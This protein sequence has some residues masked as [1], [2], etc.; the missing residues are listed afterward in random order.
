[1]SSTA[2]ILKQFANGQIPADIPEDCEYR[3]EL[4]QLREYLTSLSQFVK[5]LSAGDLSNTTLR[6]PGSL[7]GSLKGLHANLR[8]L[9]W[10]TQQVAA[11]DLNQRVDFLGDFSVAFNSMVS[12]LAQARDDLTQKNQQLSAAYDELKT[13]QLQLLQQEKMASVGQLAAG[14]AHEINNPMAFVTSNLK[15]LKKY[16]ESLAGFITVQADAITSSASAELVAQ[17]DDAKKRL[18]VNNILADIHDL[19]HEST[20][21]AERVRAIVL[22][23]KNFSCLNES[24]YQNADLNSCLESTINIASSGLGGNTEVQREYGEIPEIPCQ[25]RQLNQVFL[26]LLANAAHAITDQ[27]IIRVQTW[28]DGDDVCVAI[29]DN[30]CGIPEEIQSRI[31]EP[32]FTTRDVGKGTGLGLSTCYDIVKKHNG[33]IEVDSKVG[34]GSCFTVYLPINGC[35]VEAP[36]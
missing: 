32:F 25:P 34:E 19:I 2:T 7:A 30:G 16:S 9:S 18:K 21:G 5:T 29:R 17:V 14:V 4:G 10:Q 35:G 15:T 22:N 1:M 23:L 3:E 8:H 36:S 28:R 6:Q 24:E 12:S 31:F 26:N 33:R 11:G 27:G 13:T 20:E